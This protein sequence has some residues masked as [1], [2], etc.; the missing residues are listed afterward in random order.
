MFALRFAGIALISAIVH[1]DWS[2]IPDKIITEIING[3]YL[4]GALYNMREAK[5]A[6]VK[7]GNETVVKT[8]QEKEA[9]AVTEFL[10]TEKR[11]QPKH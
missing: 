2:N 1:R 11:E 7:N 3:F 4:A 6:V 8:G 10:P 5:A 9:Q